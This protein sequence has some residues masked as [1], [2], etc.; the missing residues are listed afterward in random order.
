MNVLLLIKQVVD[1]EARVKINDAKK[2]IATEGVKYALSPYDE[3]ALEEGVRIKEKL[4]GEVTAM[5]LGPARAKE[6]LRTCLAVGADKAVHLTD[7]AFAGADAY[8]T[9]QA[10][11]AAARKF[12]YDVILCGK[13]AVGVDRGVT[14]AAVAQLLGIPFVANVTKLEFSADNKKATVTRDVEGGQEVYE[15]ELPAVFSCE[16]G[17]NTLRHT[18]LKGIM[19]AKSKPIQEL[20][21]ADLGLP[22]A[23]SEARVRVE[24]ME[25][26]PARQG[27]RI[28]PGD[29]ETAVKELV[30]LLHEEAK[31][32]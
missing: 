28:V 24:S 14:G 30:R 19:M 1:T 5:S 23:K 32:I 15:V 11:A 13:M 8:T 7:P 12:S 21:A 10:L 2:N 20:K 18:P 27:G 4:G 17:L 6:A 26:P 9:A 22:E 31:V 29:P 16:K 25:Y 3:F